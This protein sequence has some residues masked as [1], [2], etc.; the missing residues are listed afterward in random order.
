MT[1]TF[2]FIITREL[3]SFP[4]QSDVVNSYKT[5]HRVFHKTLKF[6]VDNLEQLKDPVCV[7]KFKDILQKPSAQFLINI[8]NSK[9][10]K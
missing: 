8:Q 9:V 10:F 5:M 4:I 3:F 2:L 7:L 6:S 1:E